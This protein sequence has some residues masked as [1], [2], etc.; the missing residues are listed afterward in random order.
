MIWHWSPNY[1]FDINHHISG[2][3]EAF[4]VYVL[5]A[6][7]PTHPVSSAV[8]NQG[9]ARNGGIANGGIKYGL[10]VVIDHAGAGGSVG[11][12]FFSHYSFLAIDPRGLTDAYVNYGDAT[13]NHAKIQLA[14]SI[15][16]PNH[17]GGYSAEVWGLTAS[18]TRNPDGSTGYDVHTIDH[19]KGVITP[20]AAASNMPYTPE[21][22]IAFLKYCYEKNYDKLV[23][24]CGPYDAF[25]I[26][27][28][29]YTKRYLAID[30]GT[31][32]PMIENYRSELLWNLFMNAPDVRQGMIN[33]GFHSSQY[34]F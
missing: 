28:N 20:T 4:A 25:S 12:M 33:L 17:W 24:A 8:Y 34:G 22:S 9:W 30:Q 13:K 7:S 18:E 26:H 1:G 11:P 2:Y 31:I 29:W 19:D 6:C 27:Y 21:A 10:P 32:A 14:Y 23:G 5:A 3:N 16:N 15:A